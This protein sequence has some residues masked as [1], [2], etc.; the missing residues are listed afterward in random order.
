MIKSNKKN[1]NE[2]HEIES[3][4]CKWT[5]INKNV[6]MIND[7]NDLIMNF[8]FDYLFLNDVQLTSN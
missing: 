1:T 4:K 2:W 5:I 7:A 8:K 3:K 6:L